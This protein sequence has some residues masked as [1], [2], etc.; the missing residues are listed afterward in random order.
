MA[1]PANGGGKIARDVTKPGL[2]IIINKTKQMKKNHIQ[3]SGFLL[4]AI[5]A[6]LMA[7]CKAEKVLPVNE[8]VKDI[9]G[10]WQ[11]VRATRN[12]TDLTTIIDFSQFRINFKDGGYSMVNKLPFLVNDDGKFSLD[13]PQYP[14]KIT[15]T[16][17]GATAV[18]T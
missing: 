8:A 13:D 18:S 14:F 11:V 15:F 5:M 7:S 16:A 6:I 10:S 4:M 3:Q 12:G 17:N 1:F 2:L 9:S